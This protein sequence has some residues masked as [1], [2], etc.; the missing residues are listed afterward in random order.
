M[1]TLLAVLLAS[2]GTVLYLL[3]HRRWV[4]GKEKNHDDKNT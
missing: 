3:A 4:E 2:A 1:I